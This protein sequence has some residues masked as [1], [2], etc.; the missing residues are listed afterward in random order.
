MQQYKDINGDSGVAAYE[1]GPGSITVQF[2]KGGTY[3]YDY[4]KP[5]AAHVTEMQRLAQAGN[6]LNTYINKFVR[7]DYAQKL[8]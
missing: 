4:S 2:S 8:A 1:I 6:G 7:K 5:G 3:L